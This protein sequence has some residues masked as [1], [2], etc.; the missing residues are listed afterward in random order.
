VWTGLAK[1]LRL[2]AGDETG[3]LMRFVMDVMQG[4]QYNTAKTR[5]ACPPAA[6]WFQKL[7]AAHAV[8]I[9]LEPTTRSTS[10]EGTGR[11]AGVAQN[12]SARTTEDLVES[13][14]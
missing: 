11:M 3:T 1:A 9:V 13:Q 12:D 10:H 7:P 14:L 8:Y 4:V 6:L 5:L 2:A